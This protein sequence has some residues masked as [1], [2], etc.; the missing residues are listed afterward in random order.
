[1][2]SFLTVLFFALF[3]FSSATDWN[4]ADGPE[5][6]QSLDGSWTCDGTSQ[7]P[8]DLTSPEQHCIVC[9]KDNG[10][11]KLSDAYEAQSL[12]GVLENNGHT[13]KNINLA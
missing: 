10:P 5:N 4:Y 13:G 6:W 12:S 7:S 9:D 3:Q 2:I 1:M 11:L 8:I